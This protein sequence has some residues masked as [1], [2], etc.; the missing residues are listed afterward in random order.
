M[1]PREPD[2]RHVRTPH[3]AGD[4]GVPSPM[5]GTLSAD[6]RAWLIDLLRR[7]E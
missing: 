2:R 5:R 6:D 7:S 3:G 4:G 1:P